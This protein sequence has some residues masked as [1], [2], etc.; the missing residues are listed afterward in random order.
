MTDR[1]LLYIVLGV[2][3]VNFALLLKIILNDLHELREMLFEHL[4]DHANQK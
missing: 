4:R 1:D 3:G 2:S